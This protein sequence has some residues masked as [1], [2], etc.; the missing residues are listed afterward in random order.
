MDS[1]SLFSG[2]KIVTVI[3]VE[4]MAYIMLIVRAGEMLGGGENIK[5]RH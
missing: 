5:P 1:N 2:L 4:K 3:G